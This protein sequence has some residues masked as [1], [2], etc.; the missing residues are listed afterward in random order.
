MTVKRSIMIVAV[1]LALA[2]SLGAVDQIHYQDDAVLAW[3]PI[4]YFITE[5]GSHVPLLETDTVTYE[6]FSYPVGAVV[7]D[8]DVTQLTS[9][10][11]TETPEFVIHFG[12]LPRVMYYAGVRAIVTDGSGGITYSVI[13][14]SY[15]PEVVAGLPF[16]YIPLGG[17]LIVPL[18]RGLRDAGM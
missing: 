12:D 9:H 18:P 17:V 15:D 2:W 7:D 3:D 16:A 5:D 13:A 4:T 1:L 8:Q 11:I 10:G 6:V 14:W